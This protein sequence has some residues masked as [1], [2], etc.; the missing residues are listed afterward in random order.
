[1]PPM[2]RG[3]EPQTTEVETL[4]LEILNSLEL[5]VEDTKTYGRTVYNHVFMNVLPVF[6]VGAERGLSV[7]SNIA[8]KLRGGGCF[9][10]VAG[11]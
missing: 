7:I 11:G 6:H 1:M 4:F 10:L 8:I 3:Q 9:M 2:G 5:L